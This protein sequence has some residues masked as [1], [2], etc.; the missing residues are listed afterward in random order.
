MTGCFCLRSSGQW[1]YEEENE[2]DWSNQERRRKLKT[3]ILPGMGADSSMYGSEHRELPDTL[4]PDWPPYQGEQSVSE[5]A[6]RIIEE[7]GLG[8]NCTIGGSSLGGMVAAEIAKKIKVEKLILIGSA[9]S[10]QH[11]NPVLKKLSALSEIAPI[12]LVQLLAG[13]VNA[14]QENRLL[15]MFNKADVQFIRSMCKAVFEWEGNEAPS[16]KV[17]QIHG[18]RDKVIYPNGENTKIIPDGGHLIAMSH[19]Q[20]VKRFVEECVNL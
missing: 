20:Q 3:V 12:N 17:F 13:K 15:K 9:L 4:F 16:C 7:H 1:G 6:T 19:P 5:L 2:S 10:P 11:I 8:A 18:A 14:F